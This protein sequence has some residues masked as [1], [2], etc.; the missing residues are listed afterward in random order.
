MFIIIQLVYFMI[1]TWIQAN[2]NSLN[3]DYHVP[4]RYVW[5]IPHMYIF[6]LIAVVSRYIVYTLSIYCI[7]YLAEPSAKPYR[8]SKNEI[9]PSF[10][11]VDFAF[12]HLTA[13]CTRAILLS[14]FILREQFVSHNSSRIIEGSHLTLSR[15][16]RSTRHVLPSCSH[17]HYFLMNNARNIPSSA[18]HIHMNLSLRI[19]CEIK[20]IGNMLFWWNLILGR[21]LQGNYCRKTGYL[22]MHESDFNWSSLSLIDSVVH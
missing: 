6:A 14:D 11:L 4:C 16:S 21:P 7:F 2:E 20:R 19:K 3:Y 5:K 12:F 18:I 17:L 15:R 13:F 10:L 1:Y 8:R 22:C 9:N